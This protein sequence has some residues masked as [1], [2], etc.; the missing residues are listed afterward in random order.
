MAHLLDRLRRKLLPRTLVNIG[1]M[2]EVSR[3]RT[4]SNGRNHDA[5]KLVLRVASKITEFFVKGETAE[6]EVDVGRTRQ[7]QESG[8]S[9]PGRR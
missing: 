3:R 6:M 8:C 1:F 9:V 7:D 2:D 5:T 4:T